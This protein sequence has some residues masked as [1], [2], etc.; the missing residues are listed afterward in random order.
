[1][2]CEGCGKRLKLSNIYAAPGAQTKR[3]ECR[4]CDRV[5]TLITVVYC[6]AEER[7]SGAYAVAQKIKNGARPRVELD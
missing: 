3:A 2:N 5:Y 6:E 4:P 1:M 7:G